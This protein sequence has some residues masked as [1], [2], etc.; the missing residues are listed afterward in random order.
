[1]SQDNS[2]QRWVVFDYGLPTATQVFGFSFEVSD[3]A[4]FQV[5]GEYNVNHQF[6]Q[7]PQYRSSDASQ[8]VRR[9]GG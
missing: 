4:G 1:M 7:L 8:R 6:R 2:N 5:Y 3:W 9:V